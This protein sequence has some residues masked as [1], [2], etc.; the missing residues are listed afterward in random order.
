MPK[1]IDNQRLFAYGITSDNEIMDN[2]EYRFRLFGED[3]SGYI[4]TVTE[5]TKGWQN[6]HYHKTIR[7]LYIVQKNR[8]IFVK[9][10]NN[11]VKF[12]LVKEND[13]VLTKPFISHNIF[14]PE[15]TIIHTV[16]FGKILPNDWYPSE[17]L[18]RL[19]RF[20]TNLNIN[21]LL[22]LDSYKKKYNTAF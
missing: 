17:K 20:N 8:M 14:L 13:Y 3:G 21:K 5:N 7:E 18:D 11:E 2:G 15:N 10:I 4:R 1:K 6:S 19:T 9:L 12:S 16:K 22:N